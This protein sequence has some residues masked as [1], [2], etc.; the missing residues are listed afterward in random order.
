M[1]L[2]LDE[3]EVGS[4]GALIGFPHL[5]IC[6]GIVILMDNGTLVGAHVSA[7]EV[8][9]AVLYTLRRK[10]LEIGGEMRRFYLVADLDKHLRVC[11]M[12][13]IVGKAKAIGYSGPGYVVD[14]GVLNPTD[15]SY[16]QVASNGGLTAPT[17]RVKLNQEMDYHSAHLQGPAIYKVKAGRRLGI[18]TG[19]VGKKVVASNTSKVGATAKN[20]QDLLTPFVKEVWLD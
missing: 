3:E 6:G 16:A 9:R 4:D 10:T 17:V 8:E 18:S 13:D 12:M 11:G 1:A 14:L 7:R 19:D 20:G 15:G 5:V 2:F